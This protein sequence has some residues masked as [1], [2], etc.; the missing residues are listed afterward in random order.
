MA[1]QNVRS[2]RLTLFPVLFGMLLQHDAK[3]GVLPGRLGLLK[4]VIRQRKEGIIK[5]PLADL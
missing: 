2:F 4:K 1:N 5:S 3:M